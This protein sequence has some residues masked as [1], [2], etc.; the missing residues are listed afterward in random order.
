MTSIAIE[1]SYHRIGCHLVAVLDLIE[2]LVKLDRL[3]QELTSQ[4]FKGGGTQSDIP[5]TLRDR[6]V[7]SQSH[8]PRLPFSS[9]LPKYSDT[10]IQVMGQNF[11]VDPMSIGPD[12]QE[13]WAA[14]C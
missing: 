4:L 1:A 12:I 10:E 8:Y 3:Q 5:Y 11:S 7:A 9:S 14:S 2:D 6:R 13:R